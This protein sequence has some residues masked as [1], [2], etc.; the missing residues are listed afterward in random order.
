MIKS[1]IFQFFN[2]LFFDLKVF[3]LKT[4][5]CLGNRVIGIA[6]LKIILIDITNI[7]ARS[8]NSFEFFV[9]GFLI[10]FSKAMEFLA[11]LLY[12]GLD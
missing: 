6:T 3:Y 7:K 5:G 4:L 11:I 1:L 10:R 8:K 9:N 12:F 2:F